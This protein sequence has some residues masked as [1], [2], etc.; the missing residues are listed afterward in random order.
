M[1][2]ENLQDA[3]MIVQNILSQPLEI[4]GASKDVSLL[5]AAQSFDPHNPLES[6]F[7]KILAS[8][9][10]YPESTQ[11]LIKELEMLSDDLKT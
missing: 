11:L 4:Q 7:T 3:A 1:L 6:D 5:K 9:L 8:L 2:R 10:A